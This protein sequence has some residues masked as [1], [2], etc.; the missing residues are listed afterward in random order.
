M[1]NSVTFDL[2]QNITLPYHSDISGVIVIIIS[3]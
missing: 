1:H 2:K 3:S